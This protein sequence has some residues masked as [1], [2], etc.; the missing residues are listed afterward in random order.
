MRVR[1][2]LT[3]RSKPPL[4]KRTA[5][6][7]TKWLPKNVA[8]QV[9]VAT[10][11][12]WQRY[13]SH[14]VRAGGGSDQPGGSAQGG[15]GEIK[16]Y[17]GVWIGVRLVEKLPA[18]PARKVPG[19]YTPNSGRPPALLL[20]EGEGTWKI[21]RNGNRSLLDIAGEPPPCSPRLPRCPY[22]I[23]LRPLELER[24]IGEDVGEGPHRRLSRT[25][26][27]SPYLKASSTFL[28]KGG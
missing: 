1:E 11:G 10:S 18:M 17:Q 6:T 2:L 14:E 12:G 4:A 26:K 7:Q 9:S 24:H 23:G 8:V 21:E 27:S 15:G 22:T 25:R 3:E 13:C 5:A 19:R 28:T 16:D 20:L